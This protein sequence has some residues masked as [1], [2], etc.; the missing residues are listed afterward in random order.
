MLNGNLSG[1]TVVITGAGSGIGLATAYLAAERGAHVVLTDRTEDR[2]KEA[3]EEIGT[4][5]S[6]R[7]LDVT[8]SD[9]IDDVMGSIGTIDHL[10]TPA[11]GITMAPFTELSEEQVRDFFETK[12]WGQYR[13]VRAALPHIPKKTG[14]ITLVS[15]YL[16]RKTELNCSAFAAVNGAVEATVKSLAIELAPLRVNAIAPGPVDTH[17][18]RMSTDEHRAFRDAVSAQLPAG[19]PGTAEELAHSVLYLMENTFTTGI[20]LDVDGG[21]R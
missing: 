3:A 2:I 10:F 6:Y 16:Y 15:G 17:A 13:C 18:H 12:W 21:K 5:A 9:A 1:K 20:T 14:S 19:R 8:D 4:G 7:V 11:A